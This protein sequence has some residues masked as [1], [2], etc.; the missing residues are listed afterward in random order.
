MI[1]IYFHTADNWRCLIIDR[2][3]DYNQVRK[4]ETNPCVWRKLPYIDNCWPG[5]S[6][7]ERY[8]LLWAASYK[9]NILSPAGQSLVALWNFSLA[10][11]ISFNSSFMRNLMHSKKNLEFSGHYPVVGFLL[12]ALL[13][14]YDSHTFS[15]L[16]AADP[17]FQA[18]NIDCWEG[19]VWF[20]LDTRFE[21]TEKN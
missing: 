9:P 13:T 12:A 14:P 11:L 3:L 16:N 2:T 1:L 21:Q 4:N 15:K 5:R 7:A 19:L 10:V 17:L 20:G 18:V 8:L 6:S